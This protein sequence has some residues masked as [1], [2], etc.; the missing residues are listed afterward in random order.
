M[1]NSATFGSAS[2]ESEGQVSLAQQLRSESHSFR[3][4]SNPEYEHDSLDLKSDSIRLVQVLPGQ[5]QKIH[6][7]IK[8]AKTT[9][10]YICL[11]YVWGPH[12]DT[13][14]IDID[15]KLF[16]VRRNLWEFLNVVRSTYSADKT[17]NEQFRENDCEKPYKANDPFWI[18]ALCINQDDDIERCHQVQQMGKIYSGAQLVLAWLGANS[19]LASLFQYMR[20]AMPNQ[21]FFD[22]E[23]F[24]ALSELS[25]HVYWK[26]AWITQEIQL[27]R[28]VYLFAEKQHLDLSFF[29]Q[30][31]STVVARTFSRFSCDDLWRPFDHTIQKHEGNSLLDNLYR[32]RKK[33]CSNEL[34]LV[35]SLCSIS[36]DGST[37]PI[38]YGI[39]LAELA[40]SILHS[41]SDDLCFW[42]A[43]TTLRCL[44]MVET[45]DYSEARIF[46]NIQMKLAN[47]LEKCIVCNANVDWA[48]KR[49]LN[50]L[51]LN[52]ADVFLSCSKCHHEGGI[53]NSFHL[54]MIVAQ[55]RDEPRKHLFRQDVPTNKQEPQEIVGVEF[56]F[57]VIEGEE[58]ISLLQMPLGSLSKLQVGP[59]DGPDLKYPVWHGRASGVPHEQTCGWSV[60]EQI[61]DV[62]E[63]NSSVD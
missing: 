39:S 30:A 16:R 59:F 47:D 57:K 35:Y 1:D 29:Q 43:L 15:G 5:S 13:Q 61:Q 10:R 54:L 26:R 12:E 60:T 36:S 6:C 31:G 58:N 40:R 42:R 44:R 48:K 18:D 49:I 55:G 41:F 28:H 4:A 7:T 2:I 17:E 50:E 38:R 14:A 23:Y 53:G 46:F 52:S 56:K 27:A 11:S 34:D 21:L 9:D 3:S 25:Q 20:V 45:D 51:K 19:Q 63:T 24:L 37:F 32:F 8:Q 33:Q 62:L 22:A